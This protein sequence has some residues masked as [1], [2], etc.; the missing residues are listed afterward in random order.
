MGKTDLTVLISHLVQTRH[1]RQKEAY[2]M[3][4]FQDPYVGY[5]IILFWTVGLGNKA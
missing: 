3:P 5:D 4:V 2:K 1:R